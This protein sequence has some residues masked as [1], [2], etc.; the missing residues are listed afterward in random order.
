MKQNSF[1]REEHLRKNDLI[2][3]VFDRGLPFKGKLISLYILQRDESSKNNRVAF[4]VKKTL[5]NKKPVLRNRIRRVLREG[6]RKTKS[7]L[8][9]YYDILIL[10][11]NVRKNTK[12]TDIEKEIANVFKNRIKK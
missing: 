12:S 10:A 9:G 6:Y 2:K 7:L 4:L 5:Y 8:S 3:N 1:T 11:T